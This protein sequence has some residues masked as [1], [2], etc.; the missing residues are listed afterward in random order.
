MPIEYIT[1]R[2]LE[3]KNGQAKGK[4]RI[5]KLKEDAK[6]AVDFVCPECCNSEKM[7]KEWSEPFLEGSGT[8]QKFSISC[9]C[10]YSKKILKLKKEVKKK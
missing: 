5:L 8:N 6:A 1:T 4:I 2:E 7:E 9:K 3:N 10:G